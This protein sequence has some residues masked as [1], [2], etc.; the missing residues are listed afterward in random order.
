MYGTCGDCGGIEC[1]KRCA[2]NS[3][4]KRII[5][6]WDTLPNEDRQKMI[7]FAEFSSTLLP[8]SVSY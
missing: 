7:A 8:E 2:G 4:L 6:I 1:A 5:E 3:D